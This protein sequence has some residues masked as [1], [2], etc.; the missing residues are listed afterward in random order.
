MT[1]A[2]RPRSRIVG[3]VEQDEQPSER[4]RP[5]GSKAVIDPHAAARL[6]AVVR[7]GEFDEHAA[8]GAACRGPRGAG[9]VPSTVLRA[10]PATAVA[11]LAIACLWTSGRDFTE[12]SHRS[13]HAAPAD[14]SFATPRAAAGPM[15]GADGDPGARDGDQAMSA[16]NRM[17]AA[18]VAAAA[19]TGSALAQDA[20]Q[21]RVEDGGNGHWYQCINSGAEL[22]WSEADSSARAQGGHLASITSSSE[23][24]FVFH[25]AAS[26]PADW[27]G[28]AKEQGPWLGGLLIGGGWIWSTGESMQFTA[29]CD[30]ATSPPERFT[31]FNHC[32][33]VGTRPASTWNDHWGEAGGVSGDRLPVAFIVEWSADCNADSIVDYGQILSGQLADSNSNGIPDLCE[34]ATN[35]SLPACCPGDIYRNGVVDGA[36]LGILLSEWGPVNPSTNSDLDGNGNVNGA[37]LGLL[38]AN[39]GACG[40]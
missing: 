15:F 2:S 3:G 9:G 24:A 1:R 12:F 40:G 35:P 27:S 13:T 5:K 31:Q 17:R 6:S 20:V 14:G 18:V 36:D 21:W 23:N 30:G 25:H 11:T 22:R 39:W 37:D 33:G 32:G 10:V 28:G 4:G 34:C 7:H 26:D 38:L 16:K 29:W 8:D 19:T